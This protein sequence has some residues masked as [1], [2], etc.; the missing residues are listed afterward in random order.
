MVRLDGRAQTEQRGW[1]PGADLHAVVVPGP[2]HLLTTGLTFYRDRSS[3]QRTTLTTTS[4]VG[5]VVL[6]ARGP[7]A[8]RFPSPVQLGP[9]STSH[10]V[11]VPDASL[12]HPGA[13]AEE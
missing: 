5:Q 2:A 11:R 4:M 3:D 9:P 10:P 1:T 12:S 8:V 13:L 7:Q 6:G